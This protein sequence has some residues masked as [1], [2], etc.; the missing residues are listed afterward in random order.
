MSKSQKNFHVP[1]NKNKSSIEAAYGQAPT[2]RKI[3]IRRN[4][5]ANVSRAGGS[6][7][8]TADEER[9]SPIKQ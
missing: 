7:F 9:F 6:D 5:T 4:T 3:S 1:F 2:E 8:M